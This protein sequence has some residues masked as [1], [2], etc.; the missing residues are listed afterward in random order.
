MELNKNITKDVLIVTFSGRQDGLGSMTVF[1]FKNFLEEQY[2]LYD[3]LFLKDEKVLWY[4]QG[5]T[6]LSTNV[7]E[8]IDFLH[9]QILPY[10]KVVFIGASMGGYAALLYGSILKVDLV[11]TFRPQTHTNNVLENP[12]RKY[13][14]VKNFMTNETKYYIYGD[15]SLTDENDIHSINYCDRISDLANIIRIPNFDIKNY[16][17]SGMLAFD[18]QKMFSD[19]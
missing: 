15:S 13:D 10:K 2:G 14:D 19:L 6:G 1:E 9:K 8:T 17:K 16:K 18:F 11:I 5:I 12:I 4:N 7:E 3:K